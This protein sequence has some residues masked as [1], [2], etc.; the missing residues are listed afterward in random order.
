MRMYPQRPMPTPE[1]IH[2][3]CEK[4]RAEWT[5]ETEAA[6]R[7]VKN[8]PADMSVPHPVSVYGKQVTIR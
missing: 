2:A 3:E 1:E 8:K 7:M 6:R 5:P 4:I